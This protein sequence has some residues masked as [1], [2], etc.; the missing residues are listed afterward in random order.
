MQ[1]LNQLIKGLD[2]SHIF[3]YYILRTVEEKMASIKN[4]TYLYLKDLHRTNIARKISWQV[5][6]DKNLEEK[7]RQPRS[8]RNNRYLLNK[9]RSQSRKNNKHDEIDF[10]PE[11]IRKVKLTEVE[12]ENGSFRSYIVFTRIC[13]ITLHPLQR[14]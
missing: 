8:S 6:T 9:R 3:F 13:Q 5:F 10:C 14:K 12:R 7:Y 11:D 4:W 1:Y 2:T